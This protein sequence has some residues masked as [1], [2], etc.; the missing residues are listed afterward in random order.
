MWAKKWRRRIPIVCERCGEEFEHGVRWIKAHDALP[1]PACG[2]LADRKAI[3]RRIS[4]AEL[5]AIAHWRPRK[6]STSR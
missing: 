6:V 1:C 3:M 4:K 5:A 2:R